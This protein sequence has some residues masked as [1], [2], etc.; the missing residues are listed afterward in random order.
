MPDAINLLSGLSVEELSVVKRGANGKRIAM[1]KDYAMEFNE[2]VKNVVETPAEGEA[3]FL[4][5][6]K[7]HK[8]TEEQQASA[9]AQFRF[10]KGFKDKVSDEVHA[11]VAKAAGYSIA[12]A[13]AK[14]EED[15]EDEDEDKDLPAFLQGK[16][17]KK[18]E[19]EEGMKKR[20]DDQSEELAAMRKS[21]EAKDKLLK[22]AN[23]R[24]E[25]IEKKAE[26]DSLV[27]RCEKE[28]PYVPGMTA[29]TQAD[30]LI[31]VG[32]A[33]SREAIEKSWKASS[34]AAESNELLKTLGNNDDQDTD[35]T[36]NER[37]NKA[38]AERM[39]KSA[40]L[41]YGQALKATMKEMPQLAK[42]ASAE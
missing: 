10:S 41:T 16:K 7:S 25:K 42:E 4:E 9:V 24:I 17:G 5:T 26:R 1:T 2:T 22:S 37:L 28:F 31:S 32:D 12:K 15:E 29:D 38:V 27:V 30:I 40:D 19:M 34:K 39:T 11:E 23:D 6:L 35:G 14:K 8:L 20:F 33:K 13:K 3:E 21:D 18:A 36:A